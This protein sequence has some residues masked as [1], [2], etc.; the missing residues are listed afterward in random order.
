MTIAFLSD[1]YNNVVSS[2]KSSMDGFDILGGE[3][4]VDFLTE[5]SERKE[6]F[7][8][9]VI[10]YKS[11]GKGSEKEDLLFL[12]TYIESYSPNLELVLALS[13]DEGSE[14]A[15]YFLNLFSSPL[16]TVAYLPT[17]TTLRFLKDLISLDILEVKAMYYTLDAQNVNSKESKSKP[18]EKKKGGLFGNWLGG[19]K[20]KSKDEPKKEEIKEEKTPE[21]SVSIPSPTPPVVPEAVLTAPVPNVAEEVNPE[22][23][24]YINSI[25]GD[26]V[27]E[28]DSSE[29]SGDLNFGLYGDS[30]FQ[31]GVI[32]EEDDLYSEDTP[33]VSIGQESE[34]Q[35]VEEV[36]NVVTDTNFTGSSDFTPISPVVNI[37]E[38]NETKSRVE[39]N[40]FSEELYPKNPMNLSMLGVTLVVGSESSKF[41]DSYL[42]EQKGYYVI[43][44][45]SILGLNSYIDERSYLVSESD[46][47]EEDGNYFLLNVTISD[48]PSLIANR[49]GNLIINV[50]VSDIDEV[51]RVVNNYDSIVT[52]YSDNK[53]S[54]CEQLLE[55]EKVKGV[56]ARKLSSCTAYIVGVLSEEL[57]DILNTALFSKIDWKGR[58]E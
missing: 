30:H 17:K 29:T 16:Y 8:R 10:S 36:K 54:F 43:D 46:F 41:I 15:E 13:R 37:G 4:L 49:K 34:W 38:S 55:F 18:K 45:K 44:T 1:N 24:G 11:L 3:D 6:F 50:S 14:L 27:S 31:T 57:K 35:S 47:Y 28:S 5:T 33:S 52:V 42:K 32:S 20:S 23:K 22:L 56:T 12:K 25:F 26:N 9:L 40:D 48:L 58:F 53:V 51:L 7:T 2:L 21:V 39:S 19:S